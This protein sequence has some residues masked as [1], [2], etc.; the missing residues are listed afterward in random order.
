MNP[1][2][3]CGCYLN[4]KNMK[5]II[6]FAGILFFFV[7]CTHKPFE[8]VEE[9]YPDQSPKVVRYYK[10][11]TKKL[12]L[13]E[14]SYYENGN[15][16]MAG[17][18]KNEKRNG[19]WSYWYENGKIWSQAYYSEGVENGIKTV[20]HE[21]G[22]KYYEGTIKDDKPVGVWKFWDETGKQVKEVDYDKR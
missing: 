8:V 10:D 7:A 20:W 3:E 16:R 2:K 22:Q 21:N 14:I 17:S 11:E 1:I 4:D 6:L 5:K 19:K 18:Y 12:L 9:T 15:K 13:S